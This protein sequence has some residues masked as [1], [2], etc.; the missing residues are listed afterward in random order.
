MQDLEGS[1][2]SFVLLNG[3]SDPA[4]LASLA[5]FFASLNNPAA[6]DERW[7]H[8]ARQD[9]AFARNV[10]PDHTL[11]IDELLSL[12]QLSPTLYPPTS[13]DELHSLLYNLLA[14][15]AGLLKSHCIIFYLLLAES[16]FTPTTTLPAQFARE[17]NLPVAFTR[18]V[19]A[20]FALDT[21]AWKSGVSALTDP[22][23]TPDFVNKTLTLLS[24]LPPVD[25]R[26]GLVL[27]FWRLGGIA[28]EGE[29]QA[30]VIIDALCD[31]SRRWGVG[32]AWRMQRAWVDE[33]G[34]ER[35]IRR[36]LARCFGDNPT[37]TPV[38][39]HIT[40]LLSTSFNDRENTIATS[41]CLS[42]PQSLTPRQASLA[43]DW[44]ISKFVAET[45]PVEAL[46]FGREVSQKGLKEGREAR[47]RL[48]RN[49]GETL[50]EVQRGLVDLDLDVPST[51]TAAAAST[52]SS[53]TQ[54]A[55]QP[56]P[57]QA[58]APLPRSLLSLP[59][60][61]PPKTPP[62]AGDLPLSASP[63]LRG[64]KQLVSSR[65]ASA[66]G[67]VGKSVLRALREGT[68]AGEEKAKSRVE[69]F[70]S[71]M[72]GRYGTP[73]RSESGFGG[74]TGSP[75][76]SSVF[77]GASAEGE[78]EVARKPTLSGFGSVR[79][80]ST[81]Y[82][83][84]VSTPTKDVDDVDMRPRSPPA[85]TSTPLGIRLAKDLAIAATIAAA[86]SP[87]SAPSTTTS[88]PK[89]RTF[90]SQKQAAST[91]GDKRRAV[92]TEAEERPS[93]SIKVTAGGSDFP[94]AFPGE[95]D[96]EVPAEKKKGVR[97]S[98]RASSVV[99][100][101]PRTRRA[102]SVQPSETV[103]E[104][105]RTAVR[106][107]TRRLKTPAPEVQEEVQEKKAAPKKRGGRK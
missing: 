46:K 104:T 24:T 86:N 70:G 34:Q 59:K 5:P 62:K 97:R 84:S 78:K 88:A 91:S 76:A 71:P 32:E 55:W 42:P 26:A 105:P 99:P 47:D 27:S 102:A 16:C 37:A 63:F 65:D 95:E 85:N 7:S 82:P 25:E 33:E 19:E 81:A 44:R 21:G 80:P 61:A 92:S 68:S 41:F 40:T 36:V 72:G 66:L 87:P 30:G 58:P 96:D 101:T 64:E 75:R 93:S 89:R 51:S 100:A 10:R 14:S 69:S 13:A 49:V 53:I 6:F 94:G 107:S 15:P 8:D 56:L 60:A 83:V 57:A 106:R 73:A 31:K 74:Y 43:A 50:S 17:V 39:Q 48:L 38:P 9:I 18:S 35:L 28:L 23:L 29:E 20:F 90:S 45:K 98:A 12:V 67:G 1:D 11:F 54:P 52:S 103:E 3:D 4:L 79:M 22:H 2:S 77:G